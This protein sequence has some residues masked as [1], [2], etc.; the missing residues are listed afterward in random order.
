M[1]MTQITIVAIIIA[2]LMAQ[3][4]EKMNTRIEGI[5]SI[6][7]NTLQVDAFNSIAVEGAD[8]VF[9]T[10]GPQQEVTVTGHPN[11]I[12]RVQTDVSNGTWF[13]DL[14]RGNY[15][16]YELS[17]Y[18][19]VPSMEEVSNVGS[20]NVTVT[21]PFPAE[22]MK[23]SLLGSGSFFGFPLSAS[24]CQ[25]DIIGSG[26]CEITVSSDLDVVIEGSGNVYYKG[27]PVIHEDIS[28]SGRVVDANN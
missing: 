24:T 28:G 21:G 22:H 26:E 11:I 16:S 6:T 12:S 8:N 4:C 15:G 7:T 5:G 3:S 23:V 13:V 27:S 18:I 1:K 17:Y 25:V 10:Y 9:I 20:G 14:E 2:G 19:T